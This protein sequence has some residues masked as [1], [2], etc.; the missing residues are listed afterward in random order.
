MTRASQGL[1]ILVIKQDLLGNSPTELFGEMLLLLLLL[2]CL[3]VHVR[4]FCTPGVSGSKRH[5][6]LRMSDSAVD[7]LLLRAARG[8]QVERVPVWMMRQAGRHMQGK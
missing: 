4:C 6:S 7:P 5:T 1:C 2:T 8:E 3:L